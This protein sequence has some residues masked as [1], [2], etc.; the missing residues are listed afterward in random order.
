MIPETKD[1]RVL[2]AIPWHDRL[3][4]GTTD[5]PVKDASIE[6]R[7]DASEI[8]FMVSH[9]EKYLMRGP[10]PDEIKSVFSGIRPLM[11]GGKSEKTSDLS[12]SHNVSVSKSGLLSVTGGKWTTYRQ[13][14]EDTVNMAIEVGELPSRPCA[15]KKLKL[16]GWLYE[17]H[18]PRSSSVYGTDARLIRTIEDEEPAL[19][20]PIHPSLP[21]KQSEIVWAARHEMART[22]EDAL[23]RRTRSLLLDATASIEA[24]PVVARLMAREPGRDERWIDAQVKAYR[25]L[26]KGYVLNRVLA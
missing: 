26:A 17:P 2:F 10:N 11:T 4:V 9:L 8:E 21:Y 22:V 24:A 12:R 3:L 18:V 5:V 19:S 25:E 15:T 7:P 14:A 1:G 20:E 16:H 6:P 13:M 23:S